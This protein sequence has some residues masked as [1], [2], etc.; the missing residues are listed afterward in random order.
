MSVKLSIVFYSRYGSTAK[1]AESIAEGAKK[2]DNTEIIIRKVRE[3]APESVIKRDKRWYE[4]N[5][6]MSERYPEPT[7]QLF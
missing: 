6:N 4:A 2:V 1:L 7:H 5:L 3:T